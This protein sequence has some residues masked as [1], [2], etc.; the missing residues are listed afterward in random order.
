MSAQFVNNSQS[1]YEY[2]NSNH[3]IELMNYA[4]IPKHLYFLY[5]MRRNVFVPFYSN[6]I[7]LKHILYILDLIPFCY[8]LKKKL[9]RQMIS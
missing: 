4:I 9:K 1:N 6:S 5:L 7:R 8:A 2:A 3:I